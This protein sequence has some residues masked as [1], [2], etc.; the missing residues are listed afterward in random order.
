MLESNTACRLAEGASPKHQ[1]NL[2][3]SEGAGQKLP[4]KKVHLAA[5]EP[6]A[7]LKNSGC[8]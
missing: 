3:E 5:E 2:K 7:Y 1:L 4:G 6:T 8:C